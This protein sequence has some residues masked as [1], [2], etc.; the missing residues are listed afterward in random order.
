MIL[1][2]QLDNS[3]EEVY[4]DSMNSV[5]TTLKIWQKDGYY[6]FPR[7]GKFIPWHSVKFFYIV[8]D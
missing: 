7:M 3:I 5:H 4:C 8:E 1:R 6:N 2:A